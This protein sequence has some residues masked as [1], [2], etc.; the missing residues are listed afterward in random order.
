MKQKQ[1][2]TEVPKQGTGGALKSTSDGN[3]NTA[4]AE[5]LARLIE[6]EETMER[7][8]ALAKKAKM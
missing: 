2:K 5:R 1:R 7:R 6:E 8:I 3:R 4:R